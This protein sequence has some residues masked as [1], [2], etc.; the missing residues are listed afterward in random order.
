M[1][2]ADQYA[3]LAHL[4]ALLMLAAI[5]ACEPASALAAEEEHQV[6]KYLEADQLEYQ[7]SNGEDLF[8]WEAQGWIGG[9]YHKLWVKTQ[10]D[11]VIDG[12]MADAE[13]QFLYSQVITAF[14]DLQA[15][16]RWDPRP[17]PSRNYAVLGIQGL[18]PY[19]FEVDAAIFVSHKG[20]LSARLEAEYELLLTQRLIAKPSAE[21]N[22]ALQEVEELGIGSG[23]SEVE[24]GLR[25]RYEIVREVAPYI[26]V[27]WERK[28]GPTANFA[29]RQGEDV[30]HLAFVAGVRFWY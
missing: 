5:A 2:R 21:L 25:L 16:V 1:T 12:P 17:R 28:V 27:S 23:L 22:F 3:G 24:L 30:D 19:F 15:G 20:D 18:A 11:D 26:G 4:T 7:V 6:L 8:S 10:G 14:W 13:A 9:D 29:R